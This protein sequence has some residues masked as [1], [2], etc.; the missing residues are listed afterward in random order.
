MLD[1]TFH[2]LTGIGGTQQSIMM[3]EIGIMAAADTS[4]EKVGCVLDI[5]LVS[6]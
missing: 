1:D 4:V 6:L 3:E 5:Q 2:H